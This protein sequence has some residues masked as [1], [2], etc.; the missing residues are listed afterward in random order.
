VHEIFVNYASGLKS[1]NQIPMKIL[2]AHQS[3]VNTSRTLGKCEI[4]MQQNF[5]IPSRKIKMQWK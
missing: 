5:C 2:F 4:Q 3:L 1:Q